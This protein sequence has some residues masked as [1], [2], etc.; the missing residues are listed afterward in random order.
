MAMLLG[1]FFLATGA[2]KYE[3]L[4]DSGI[5]AQR[6]EQWSRGA[7]PGVRWYLDTLAPGVPVF[8]RLVP[9]AE[10]G[11]GAALLVGFW[12]RFVAALAFLMVLN[13]HFASGLTHRAGEFVRDGTALPVLAGL[14]ALAIGGATLPF[15]VSRE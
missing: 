7:P 1:V 10:I 14:L 13:F 5:L 8:A 15:S 12:T 4:F 3:W 6:L 11:T 9:L 2:A